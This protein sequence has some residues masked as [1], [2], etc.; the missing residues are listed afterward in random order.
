MVEENAWFC[1]RN[2][3]FRIALGVIA[4]VC[5]IFVLCVSFLRIRNR[6]LL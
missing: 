5:V 4:F 1:G 3:S 6:Q 2:G